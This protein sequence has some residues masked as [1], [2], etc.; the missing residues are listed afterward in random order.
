M[1]RIRDLRG[2]QLYYISIVVPVYSGQDYLRELFQRITVV[3]QNLIDRDWPF[4]IGELI[5]VDDGAK[6]S[7]PEIIDDLASHHSWVVALHHSTNFGQHPATITGILN[8]SG[9][10]VVTIDEDLQH[11]PEAICGLLEKI[12]TQRA[13]LIYVRAKDGSHK[14]LF[15]DASSRLAKSITGTLSGNKSLN[16]VSS[17]RVVRGTIARATASV[18]GHDTYI[19][20]ALSWYT[21]RI[22]T[23]EIEMSD[24][25]YI[26]MDASGYKFRSL[27]SHARRML[28]TGQIK[29]LRAA[30]FIGLFTASLSFFLGLALI[31]VKLLN[32]ELIAVQGWTTQMLTT[33]LIGGLNLT[34]I[35]VALEYL[36]TLTL[37]ANGRPTSFVVDRRADLDIISKLEELRSEGN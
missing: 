34:L 8:S 19:D 2:L 25:R 9:N 21:N 33:L 32:P 4:Q 36:A 22:L 14:S 5:L 15:R 3:R 31:I 1:D 12:I 26:Q 6:D 17:F 11:P 29:I 16:S 23:T 37:R 24:E 10:W 27:I 28:F 7:S 18:S 13:D 35:A 30:G 20:V